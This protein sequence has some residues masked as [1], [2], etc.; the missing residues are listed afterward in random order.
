MATTPVF[1]TWVAG[2]VVT[3]AYFN[4]NVRDAGNFFLSVPTL[5]ARQTV[6]Q[7]I[8]NSA[9]SALSMDTEDFDNDNMHS[10]VTNSSRATPVTA[11][12][13]QVS[14]ATSYVSNATGSRH[15]EIWKNGA[16]LNGGGASMQTDSAGVS[17]RQPTR[18]LTLP[19]NGTTDYVEIVAFQTSGVGLNTDVT[20]ITQPTLSVRWVGTT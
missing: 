6:A 16:A 10:T 13:Y 9:T 7:S 18:T 5:E 1:R 2:E 4:A 12:R 14:G 8:A 15:A 20:G 17:T 11:A 3:A 19:M